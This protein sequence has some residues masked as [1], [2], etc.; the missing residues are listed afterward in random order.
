M[1][2]QLKT[3]KK[4]YKEAIKIAKKDEDEAMALVEEIVSPKFWELKKVQKAFE[5]YAEAWRN[6]NEY[7]TPIYE[8]LKPSEQGNVENMFMDEVLTNQRTL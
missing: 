4:I 6:P 2:T 1:R 7:D 3:I 8:Y 5:K